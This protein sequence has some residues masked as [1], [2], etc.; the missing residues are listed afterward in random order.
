MAIASSAPFPHLLEKSCDPAVVTPL[1]LALGQVIRAITNPAMKALW[2]FPLA[3][4]ASVDGFLIFLP[5]LAAFLAIVHFYRLRRSLA[6]AN[7]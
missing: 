5:Y 1:L 3:F 4:I 7:A 2:F 6:Y